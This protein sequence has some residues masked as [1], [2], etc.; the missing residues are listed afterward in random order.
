MQLW[1]QFLKWMM[2]TPIIDFVRQYK[3][4]KS[5]RLHM[6]GHKGKKLLG[7][8]EYDITEIDGADVLYHSHGII[9]ESEHNASNLFGFN[10]FYSTEGS[11]LC[12]RAMLFL[13]MSKNRSSN[14]NYILAA[15]NVHKTFVTAVAL[16]DLD[17]KWL[18]SENNM[19]YHTCL[20]TKEMVENNL[21]NAKELPFALYLTSPDYLG[22]I[23]DIKGIKEVCQKY[24]VLLLVDN[25]HGAYLKFLNSSLHP[26]DL[27]ADMCCDSAHKTLPAVT[28]ASYLHISNNLDDYYSIHA[29]EA[30]ALFASTSPS[31][32]ILQSLDYVN[33][34]LEKN[35]DIYS[36]FCNKLLKI[37]NR[38]ANNGYII[39][40]DEAIKITID[41]KKYGYTGDEINAYLLKNNI[42]SE[43]H[44]EDYL[45]LMLSPLNTDYELDK[46]TEALL[47]LNKKEELK[48]N[49]L[50]PTIKEVCMSI[51][52]AT[53]SLRE[54]VNVD[55]ALGRILA[56]TTVSCPP[57][58]PIIV[59]GEKIDS[60][61]IK[62][63][64]YYGVKEC[65]IVKN[66][67]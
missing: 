39:I 51:R 13:A 61:D 28:G 65:S 42:V 35:K 43:F 25:A 27:G 17:V 3:D 20:I 22:N 6:P 46:M 29:K 59:S 10:T 24:N 11:S 7:F 26:I 1:L 30:L 49:N 44:D 15:R 5:I 67:A 63:F 53:F 14:R 41:A 23:L 54:K 2:K 62:M 48:K 52:E 8:E 60:N 16:L 31:Y 21:K 55:D 66:K 4:N 50:V 37:R 19:S 33:F 9:L 40:G 34:Y 64:K 18:Y 56:D 47:R 32:L 36:S 45:V 58:I 57:A 38:L 12:I